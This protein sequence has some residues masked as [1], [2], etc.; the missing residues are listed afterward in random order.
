MQVR[1]KSEIG[2][3]RPYE[4]D[5][6][7]ETRVRDLKE[8]VAAENVV[9]PDSIVLRYNGRTLEDNQTLKSA[10]V[11]DGSV[12]SAVPSH[13]SGGSC[14]SPSLKHRLVVESKLVKEEGIKLFPTS[15][16]MVW[17][18]E[19]KG[20][21]KWKN[22]RF[23]VEITLPKTYPYSSPKVRWL[24]RISPRHPNIRPTWTCLSI[25]DQ[26]WRPHYTLVTLYRSLEWL[27][28]N[29]NWSDGVHPTIYT[30]STE[31]GNALVGNIRKHMGKIVLMGIVF[32]FIMEV[33]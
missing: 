18:G 30:R 29:P 10:G 27:F 11:E 13:R 20:S 16:P 22:K 31:A 3:G 14:P 17:R 23:R 8:K 21:S 25:L 12:L 9:E 32:A 28:E 26:G 33:V 24:D 7:P 2:V 15:N 5:V 6:E 19:I 4:D 1:V